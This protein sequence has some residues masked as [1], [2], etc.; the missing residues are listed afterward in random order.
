VIRLLF[1]F[2][3]LVGLSWLIR[4]W[5]VPR[6]PSEPFR[7]P[8]RKVPK[9]TDEAMVRDRICNTFLPR[10]RALVARVGPEE[11]FFCSESCR[12]KFLGAGVESPRPAQ[13]A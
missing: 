8:R 12:K 5:L 2:L 10:S 13:K 3:T 11:H 1:W 9:T 7:S 6:R 4:R